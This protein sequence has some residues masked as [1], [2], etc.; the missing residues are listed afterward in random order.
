MSNKSRFSFESFGRIFIYSSVLVLY[1]VSKYFIGEVEQGNELMYGLLN[2]NIVTIFS[3][4]LFFSVLLMIL[5][6][7]F[8][9]EKNWKEST[10]KA[11][12][13]HFDEFKKYLE[14]TFQLGDIRILVD[15][16]EWIR[17]RDKL[18][19][20]VLEQ[21]DTN[22]SGGL[23]RATSSFY[24]I[25]NEGN[26][27]FDKLSK[28]VKNKDTGVKY[29]LLIL[30]EP[31]DKLNEEMKARINSLNTITDDFGWHFT[32]EFWARKYEFK[33]NI[34]ILTYKDYLFINLK[35]GGGESPPRD[36][37]MV[38]NRKISTMFVHW[39]EGIWSS[40]NIKDF[41]VDELEEIGYKGESFK[42]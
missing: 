15:K 26:D 11:T 40:E 8:L 5:S 2:K 3:D 38:K 12:V 25:E 4:G 37:I 1:L 13:E 10:I 6:K 36:Y 19:D 7:L 18:I 20:S 31:K 41:S 28:I 14:T 23:I 29:R 30:S 24:P 42:G 39:F 33:S 35:T 22:G 32:T 17:E 34:D 16:D 27:Y 21:E 9:A